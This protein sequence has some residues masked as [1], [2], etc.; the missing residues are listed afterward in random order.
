MSIPTLVYADTSNIL[1]GLIPVEN[2][3]VEDIHLINDGNESSS[4]DTG[5]FVAPSYVK[6]DLG[7]KYD[8]TGVY[9]RGNTN[10]LAFDAEFYDSNNTYLGK[11]NLTASSSTPYQVEYSNVRYVVLRALLPKN[12]GVAMR[13]QEFAVYGEVFVPDTIPP[14]EITN[15]QIQESD[16]SISFT[17]TNP[18]DSDFNAINIYRDSVLISTLTAGA[19]SYTDT[20][21]TKSTNYL[22]QFKTVDTS[23][24]ESFGISRSVTTLAEVDDLPPSSPTNFNVVFY[25]YKNYLTWTNPTDDDLDKINIYRD[26]VLIS[27]VKSQY[28]NDIAIESNTEYKYSIVAVDRS[29]NQSNS[30]SQYIT[31]GEINQNSIEI[32]FN[33]IIDTITSI[34]DNL[35]VSTRNIILTILT[36]TAFIIGVFYLIGLAKKVVKKSK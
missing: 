3:Y 24:N 29:G 12:S 13:V 18:T 8:I 21:L 28:Y 11:Y 2:N 10:T 6:W 15:L 7:E 1:L 25:E 22:Y 35:L 27:S 36:F 26:D 32:L 20:G 5:L 14:C 30:V 17:W 4:S 23:E 34:F 33:T 19:I 16:T 9:I 31:T